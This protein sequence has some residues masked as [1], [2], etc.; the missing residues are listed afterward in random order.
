MAIQISGTTVIDNS[1]NISNVGTVTATSF[2]GDG[3][4]LTGISTAPTTAQVLSAN[5]GASAGA[6]G[7]YAFATAGISDATTPQTAFGATRAGSGLFPVSAAVNFFA[8]GKGSNTIEIDTTSLAGT[9]RAMGFYDPWHDA[10]VSVRAT[11][12]LWLRIS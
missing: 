1:R 9:W 12:T 3:S 2:S 10:N 5:S 6:V 7:T 11:A 4:A 8:E